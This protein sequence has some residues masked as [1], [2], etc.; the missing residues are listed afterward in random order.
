MFTDHCWQV[1]ECGAAIKARCAMEKTPKAA[2]SRQAC[3]PAQCAAGPLRSSSSSSGSSSC[4]DLGSSS[5][6]KFASL[7]EAN[8]DQRLQDQEAAASTAQQAQQ[9]QQSR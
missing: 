9:A 4:S 8:V 2:L 6:N 7:A 1:I 5:A 3:K